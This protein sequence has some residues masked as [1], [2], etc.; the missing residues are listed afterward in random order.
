VIATAILSVVDE[1]RTGKSAVT[2]RHRLDTVLSR[3]QKRV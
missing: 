2:A 1:L 3:F